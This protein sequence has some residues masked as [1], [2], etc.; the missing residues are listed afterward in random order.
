MSTK[1]LTKRV[2]LA[3]VVALGAGV[4]SLVSVTS[5]T[6]AIGASANPAA[7][8]ANVAAEQGILHPATYASTSGAGTV[9]AESG[10][11]YKDN[12]KSLGL[13]AVSDTSGNQVA[14][15]TQT[16][17]LLSSGA[18]SVYETGTASTYDAIVVTGGTISAGSASA[19]FNS[20]AT[21]VTSATQ[22]GI[23]GAVVKPNA[24]VTSFTVAL[25]TSV[26]GTQAL[27]VAGGGTLASFITV[28]V[29]STGTSGVLSQTKSAIYYMNPS[30]SATALTSD[31]SAYT[32]PQSQGSA[33]LAV[34]QY[35]QIRG[36]DA[37]SAS[38]AS[39][40]YQATATNGAFVKLFAAGTAPSAT[41][42]TSSSYVT[43]TDTV[44][45]A[46]Q[47]PGNAPVS[48]TVTVTY[49]GT[50]IATKAFNFTGEVAKVVLSG[51]H[52][53]TVSGSTKAAGNYINSISF[54]DSAG[55]AVYPGSNGLP[56]YMVKNA[57]GTTGSGIDI[58]TF[59]PA[60][61]SAAATLTTKCGGVAVTGSLAIDYTNNSGT[62]ATS[63]TLPVV[64]AYTASSYSAKMDKA[65]YAPGDLATV[66]VTFKDK[67]GSL[68]ADATQTVTTTSGS[69]PTVLGGFLTPVG[70][71]TA[72]TTAGSTLD[73]S[74]N[75]VIT[76][77]FVVGAGSGTYQLQVD[78]PYLDTNYSGSIQTVA[79]KIADGAT[80]L[81]D[82]LKGIVS[83]IASINKQI[84]ALAKLVAKK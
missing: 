17:T 72:N 30:P 52:V 27:A 69:A 34:A 10:A 33:P 81:N 60:T 83:L 29:A 61:S 77:Q 38:L 73:V 74:S 54:L 20:A 63:N 78:Y 67:N 41:A 3:T 43:D 65:V 22:G 68:A 16:A 42:S 21:A 58:G 11:A 76:Y 56:V 45:M 39:G 40:L 53:G 82:V 75:G 14:G 8:A 84:A 66:T 80:S 9:Y 62:I 47:M 48:T 1:T 25:Y 15:T 64:C 7:G 24:G 4:L 35:A 57:G 12:A 44:N 50:V 13:L 2:A 32:W 51:S 18:L 79:Y 49:N 19:Y 28:T 46:V 71:T 55:N 6:A 5:A 70:G 31:Y 36:R 59:T 26:S 37:Y 23:L